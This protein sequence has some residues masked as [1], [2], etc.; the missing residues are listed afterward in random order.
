MLWGVGFEERR[1]VW[2]HRSC[3]RQDQVD[4]YDSYPERLSRYPRRTECSKYPTS[5]TRRV[6]TSPW[7]TRVHEEGSSE[8]S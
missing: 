3:L 8:Q 6:V 5:Y 2:L 4:L 7:R 1:V